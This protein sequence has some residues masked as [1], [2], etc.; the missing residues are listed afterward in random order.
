MFLFV[1]GSEGGDSDEQWKKKAALYRTV[2]KRKCVLKTFQ[3]NVEDFTLHIADFVIQI[4]EC[5]K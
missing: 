1:E 2:G 5:E 4:I 3:N